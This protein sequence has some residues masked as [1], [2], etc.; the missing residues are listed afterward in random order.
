MIQC[1][2]KTRNQLNAPDETET[3][4]FQYGAE[5]L[6]R[7]CSRIMR[8]LCKHQA[9]ALASLLRSGPSWNYILV[10]FV[11]LALCSLP[12]LHTLNPSVFLIQNCGGPAL[13]ASNGVRYQPDTDDIKLGLVDFSHGRLFILCC[14]FS[15]RLLRLCSDT[16]FCACSQPFRCFCPD[17]G[18]HHWCR[19]TRRAYLP[20]RFHLEVTVLQLVFNCV[21]LY[22][23]TIILTAMCLFH[24][25]P[26][27]STTRWWW[28]SAT[29]R[30][31]LHTRCLS[32]LRMATMYWSSNS[33]RLR[34]KMLD[35]RYYF[36]TDIVAL[37]LT[38]W[39]YSLTLHV[40]SGPLILRRFSHCSMMFLWMIA[41]A[42]VL[43]RL[44][45]PSCCFVRLRHLW[46]NRIRIGFRRVLPLQY[47]W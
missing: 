42:G 22:W 5:A 27:S 25:W 41:I 6:D 45:R 8:W 2:I 18:A 24:F 35:R 30:R 36:S 38:R 19:A 46:Q 7:S 26:P 23:T 4:W 11:P 3:S 39:I 44:Q 12:P 15:L 47:Q 14:V 1:H 33:L 21:F 9:T 40:F 28:Q 16:M 10:L 31:A 32:L 17:Q 20:N 43:G 37:I 34:L 13:T 29:A